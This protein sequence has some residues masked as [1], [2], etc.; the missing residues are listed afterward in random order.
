MVVEIQNSGPEGHWLKGD[1]T[2]QR[3]QKAEIDDGQF[4]ENRNMFW[5]TV[6]VSPL[7]GKPLNTSFIGKISGNKIT[8]TFV[9]DTGTTG[10]WTA[11]LEK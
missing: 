11:I 6:M 3:G 2:D 8:G 10:T 7:K 4:D 9:D 1:V 5:F